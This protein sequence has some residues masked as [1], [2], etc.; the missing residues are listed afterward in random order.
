MANPSQFYVCTEVSVI[1]TCRN[2]VLYTQENQNQGGGDY[3]SFLWLL[4]LTP[5]QYI[6]LGS[7]FIS[8][9]LACTLFLMYVSAI[10]KL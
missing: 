7:L 3:D 5:Q 10:K 2:W 9:T 4:S 1:N 6:E 8:A